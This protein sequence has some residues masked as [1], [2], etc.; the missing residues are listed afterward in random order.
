MLSA[1]HA[2]ARARASRDW[3]EADRLRAEIEAAGWKVVD[4]GTDFA[5]SPAHPPDVDEPGRRRYG[6]SL[7]VPSRLEDAAVGVATIVVLASRGRADLE[8]TVG[9]IRDHGPDGT[10]LVLVADDPR[11]DEA[12]ALSRLDLTGGEAPGVAA[13]VVWT[14]APLGH[15]AALNAGIRRAVAATV[16]VLDAGVEVTGDFVTPLAEALTDRAV[17]LAGPWG[18]VS[19]DLR[20]FGPGPAGDVHAVAGLCQAFRRDD[21]LARGPLDERFRSSRHL[22]VWWSLVLRDAGEDGTHRRA[23]ALDGLAA[24][25][26]RTRPPQGGRGGPR[27]MPRAGRG[28]G[29]RRNF[30]RLGHRAGERIP[31]RGAA[32]L[33]LP[34]D[35]ARVDSRGARRDLVS[36]RPAAT[37]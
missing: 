28:R 29:A 26:T 20:R 35:R 31:C 14:S 11:P 21:Y 30:Y 25:R 33:R 37:A 3:P 23:L 7:S 1:A 15:A 18:L 13:E 5:L 24:A 17:A 4:R 32:R 2:R 36:G 34:T 9:R 22:D 12:G 27:R 19:G 10:Q 8:R 6:S 16:V